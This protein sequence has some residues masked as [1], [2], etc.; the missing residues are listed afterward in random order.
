M[1]AITLTFGDCMENHAGMQKIGSMASKGYSFDDLIKASVKLNKNNIKFEII[2]LNDFLPKDL[3]KVEDSIE[4]AYVLIVKNFVGEVLS[5]ELFN[6]HIGLLPDKKYYDTRRQKVLNK[7]ARWNLCFDDFSQEPDYPNKKGRII[8]FEDVPFTDE[9]RSK[10]CNLIEDDSLKL[11]ANYYYDLKKTGIGYH[12]DTERKKVI[13]V[14]LGA[15]NEL[16]FKWFKNSEQIG[17]TF[18]TFL[19]PGDIYIMSEKAVGF[20]W[21]LRSKITL[22][23]AAGSKKYTN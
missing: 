11:E 18:R 19:E 7:L 12:G 5:K 10:I 17:T 2:H 3:E 16:A 4:D 20:D 14:R 23:H 13:G 15:K 9:L 1:D 8:R 6:E 22:R 21:K